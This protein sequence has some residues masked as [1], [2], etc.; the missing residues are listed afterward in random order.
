MN[1]ATK[2]RIVGTVV[3][4]TLAFIFFPIIFDGQGSYQPGITSRIPAPPDVF[5]LPEPVQNR[6][7]MIARAELEDELPPVVESEAGV[8]GVENETEDGAEAVAV[9]TSEPVFSRD[10]PRLDRTG[11]PEA[12]VVQLASFSDAQNAR[13]LLERLQSAGYKAYLRSVSMDQGELSRVFV[14]PWVL[15]SRADEYQDQLQQRFQLAGI[16]VSYEMKQL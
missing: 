4:L 5:V 7:I 2:Q 16:V 1:Q 6:P 12:W 11:L 13:I 15:R 14:G 3:L 9:T 10:V 8:D